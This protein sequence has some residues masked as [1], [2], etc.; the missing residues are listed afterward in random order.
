MQSLRV[1]AVLEDFQYQLAILTHAFTVQL[2]SNLQS[3]QEKAR[4][5]KLIQ[6]CQII[7]EQMRMLRLELEEKQTFSS[8]LNIVDEEEKRRMEAELMKKIRNAEFRQ[9]QELCAQQEEEKNNKHLILQELD[10]EVKRLEKED[11]ENWEKI[12]AL[13]DDKEDNMLMLQT[14]ASEKEKILEDQIKLLHQQME[15][16]RHSHKQSIKFLQSQHEE[17]KQ[18]LDQWKE[19]SKTMLEEKA[20]QLNSVRC[21]ITLN[22]DRLMEM[23]RKFRVMEQVVIEDKEEQE[24]LR[25]EQEQIEVATKIQAWWRGCMVRKGLGVYKKAE[26]GKKG[27]KNDDGKKDVKKKKKK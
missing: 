25:Q 27:K 1:A 10:E 21:K 9:K 24:K 2:N 16:E 7:S 4:L 22:L 15:K 6:D 23:R 12:K 13:T 11:R 14:E 8:L 5:N 18:Q 17:M 3:T 19:R 26:E 20:R